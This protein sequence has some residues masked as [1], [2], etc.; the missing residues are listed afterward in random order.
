M[1]GDVGYP[2]TRDGFSG[3]RMEDYEEDD[4]PQPWLATWQGVNRYILAG[5]CISKFEWFVAPDCFVSCP[6][7]LQLIDNL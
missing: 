6:N 3:R 1:E 7:V 2:P 5:T 4:R